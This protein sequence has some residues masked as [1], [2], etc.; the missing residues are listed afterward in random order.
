MNKQIRILHNDEIDL[1]KW[2]KVIGTSLNS[3]I[4]AFS[5]YLDI[6]WPDWQGIV[7]GDYEYIM[8]II[9]N[10]KFR[11]RYLFQ[12]TYAQQHGIFPPATPEIT[13]QI[14]SYILTK[15]KLI[16]IAF[17]SMNL[18]PETKS[19]KVLNKKNH[20]LS[21]NKPYNEI[22]KTCSKHHQRYIRY[23]NK[24]NLPIQEIDL[25]E[26]IQ[27]KKKN[28]NSKAAEQNLQKLQLVAHHLLQRKKGYILGVYSK[29]NELVAAALIASN[30]NRIIYLNG[31]SSNEGQKSRAMFGIFNFLFE[32]YANTNTMLDF[33]GSE[34]EGVAKFFEGFGAQP[35]TYPF[36]KQN[37]LPK[38]LQM[39]MS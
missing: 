10:K 8:P 19:Q 36:L 34:I 18:I 33:E 29:H 26:F 20:I 28:L 16:E 14:T 1:E 4:Y 13:K 22:L 25:A 2:D 12:P 31:V 17:N 11:I 23:A 35:E 37:N 21:L 32:N 24:H 9:E 5:W 30:N 27:F 7:I 39:F 38:I 15:F 6:L 3:R